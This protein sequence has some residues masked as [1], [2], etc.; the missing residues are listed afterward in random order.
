MNIILLGA[1]GSGKG[2]QAA[3]L[4]EKFDLQHISTGELCRKEVSKG[5]TLGSKLAEIMKAGQL[6]PDILIIDILK[7]HLLESSKSNKGFIFDGF[8]RTISQAK[9]LDHMLADLKLTIEHVIQIN[10]DK[11]YIVSRLSS[12]TSCAQCGH[13]YNDKTNP[14]LVSGV[15]DKCGSTEFI[16]RQDDNEEIILKRLDVYSTLTAPLIPYYQGMGKLHQIDGNTDV[17]TVSNRIENLLNADKVSPKS[18]S[19]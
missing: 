5:T 14:T 4:S 1:P 7:Q 11:N 15:C 3:L 10:V 18:A 12:R 17:E 2:T 13:V 19:V 6:I 8:P 16:H 9:D